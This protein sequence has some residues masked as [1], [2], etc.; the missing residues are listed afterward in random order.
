VPRTFAGLFRGHGVQPGEV[1][2][3]EASEVG[4]DLWMERHES[5]L[6]IAVRNVGSDHVS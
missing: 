5:V 2:C 4:L 6:P 1:D 3:G